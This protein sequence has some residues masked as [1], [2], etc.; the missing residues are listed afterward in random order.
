MAA[1]AG[2]GLLAA[3][4]SVLAASSGQTP[5]KQTHTGKQPELSLQSAINDALATN[6]RTRSAAAGRQAA[7]G[8]RTQARSALLPHLSG[9]IT[10]SRQRNNLKARGLDF[11]SAFS[12]LPLPPGQQPSFPSTITYDRFQANLSLEQKIFDY[13][14][15]QRY[16]AAQKGAHAAS[17]RL[18]AARTKVAAQTARQYVDV[19]A[20]KQK[21]TAAQA[22]AKLAQKL[23]SLA[24][25]QKRVGVA[26]AVDVAR[27]KTRKA[28]AET[29]LARARTNRTRAAIKLKR[30]IGMDLSQPLALANQLTFLPVPL[31]TADGAVQ[32]AL[33]NRSDITVAKDQVAKG[34]KNLSAARARRLPTLSVKGAFGTAGNTPT[35]NEDTTYRIGAQ[36][37]VP[38]FNGGAISGHIDSAAGQLSQDRV[39]LH[40]KQRAVAQNVRVARRT[41]QTLATEVRAAR[42]NLSQANAEL[43]QARRRFK[44]GTRNNI[45]V[46]DAQSAL[47]S[48]RQQRISALA[49]YT[50]A[51]IKRTAA[52]G[53]AQ[54]FRLDEALTHGQ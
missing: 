14:A 13:S 53:L 4:S 46:V 22:D 39:E 44:N 3:S 28:R 33:A 25:G 2:A 30:T 12:S 36:I 18:R 34:K 40:D 47:A 48:A 49:D 19:L 20:A 10:Q 31:A 15:W 42:A 35:R 29:R 21:I 16:H 37:S 7:A 27:A 23:L 45:A 32:R 9:H 17:A 50:R 1:C 52:L 24:Q 41:L 5:P 51:R 43:G 26:T 38:L 8:Q 6:P 11:G 54:R